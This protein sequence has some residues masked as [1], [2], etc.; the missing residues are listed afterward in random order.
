MK[1]LRLY[2]ILLLAVFFS[3]SIVSAPNLA[4]QAGAGSIS[5]VVTDSTGAIIPDA[6]VVITNEGTQATYPETTDRGGFYSVEGLTV[7]VYKVDVTKTGFKESIAQG[8][9]I[10]PG[11]AAR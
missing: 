6:H 2:S 8:I 5:G 11:A 1:Q 10:D 3:L 9:Q 4:A 7:G